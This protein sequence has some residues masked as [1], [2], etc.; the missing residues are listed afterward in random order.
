MRGTSCTPSSRSSLPGVSECRGLSQVSRCPLQGWTNSNSLRDG[1]K[2]YTRPASHTEGKVQPQQFPL[3]TRKQLHASSLE[4]GGQP[5]NAIRD[6]CPSSAARTDVTAS[7]EARPDTVSRDG[8]SCGALRPWG[9]GP[10]TGGATCTSCSGPSS[11][12]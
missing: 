9:C 2:N 11:R 7:Q 12:T 8:V 1:A 6:L 4:T 5:E 10:W 3:L